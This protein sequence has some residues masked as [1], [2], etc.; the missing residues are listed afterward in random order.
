MQK[1]A[2]SCIFLHKYAT[3]EN[4]ICNFAKTVIRKKV[5]KPEKIGVFS[6]FSEI[7]ENEMDGFVKISVQECIL[8]CFGGYG[9][10]LGAFWGIL[11]H[12]GVR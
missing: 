8:A 6:N 3:W 5:K 12:P 7:F 1:Y 10:T 9:C 2:T 4:E 11:G